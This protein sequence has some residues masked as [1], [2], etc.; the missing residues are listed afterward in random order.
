MQ[1]LYEPGKKASR[2]E[3]V[4]AISKSQALD[5]PMCLPLS[6]VLK[7]CLHCNEAASDVGTSL[8]H[9][10]LHAFVSFFFG[11]KNQS[12]EPPSRRERNVQATCEKD[13]FYM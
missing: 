12:M 9:S 8:V 6:T 1:A 13:I 11:R 2:P 4:R 7:H 10:F 3:R 5:Q